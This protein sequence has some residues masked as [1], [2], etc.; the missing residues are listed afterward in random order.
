VRTQELQRCAREAPLQG[1]HRADHFRQAAGMEQLAIEVMR[2]AVIAQVEPI[3]S[4]RCANSCAP[5]TGRTA[6]P[7]CPPSR[8]A[9][10]PEVRWRA[11]DSTEAL[12]PHARAAIEQQLALRSQQRRGGAQ[13]AAATP[14]GA[15]QHGLQ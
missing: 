2:V 1:V 14:G 15:R 5:A 10:P 3:T 13:D 8:A 6:S 11:P 4:K 9:A 7:R 12:Q